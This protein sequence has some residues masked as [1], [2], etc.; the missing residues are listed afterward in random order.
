MLKKKKKKKMLHANLLYLGVWLYGIRKL[1]DAA[2][3]TMRLLCAVAGFHSVSVKGEQA[4]AKE[5]PVLALAPHSSFF[6]SLPVVFLGAPSV[7]AKGETGKLPF[8]GSMF[9]SS[10]TYFSL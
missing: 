10:L 4:S 1:R 3:K 8:I 9:L 5:A 6:D 7:V 2:C